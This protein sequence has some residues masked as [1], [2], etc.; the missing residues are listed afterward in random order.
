MKHNLGFRFTIIVLV[1]GFLGTMAY[2]GVGQG[3]L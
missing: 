1:I 2:L 3:R